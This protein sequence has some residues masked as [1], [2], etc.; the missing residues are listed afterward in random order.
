MSATIAPLR[1]A[2]GRRRTPADRGSCANQPPSLAGATLK[3]TALSSSPLYPA[4][5]APTT[6]LVMGDEKRRLSF[7]LIRRLTDTLRMWRQREK[8][9]AELARMSLYELH[10]I[11][12]STSDRWR[13]VNKPFSR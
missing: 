9:R 12:L 2:G 1:A 6:S 11:G 4:G 3:V 7:A 8:E 13:E 5:P 10:D